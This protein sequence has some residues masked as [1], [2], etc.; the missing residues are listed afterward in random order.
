MVD[1]KAFVAPNASIT[2]EVYIGPSSSIWYGCVVRGDVN[3]VSIGSGTNIQDNSL[4][5]VAKSNLSGKVLPTLIGNNVTVGHSAILHGCTVEDE[6]FIGMGATVLDGVVVEKHAMVAAGALVRQN[7]RIPAGE[8]WGGNPAKF[9]R[10]LNDDEISFISVSA[11]NYASLAQLHAAENA[12]DFDKVEFEKVL[13][14]K[15]AGQ[16]GEHD[17]KLGVVGEAP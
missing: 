5:H 6:A 9:L 2:G 12:K 16:D 4:V 13:R 14:K 8:V 11:S 17:L 1:K 7:T 15:S 10:K 3:S